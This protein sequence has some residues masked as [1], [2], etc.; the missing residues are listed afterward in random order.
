M[1][2]SREK[3]KPLIVTTPKAVINTGVSRCGITL[4]ISLSLSPL[5]SRGKTSSTRGNL[6]VLGNLNAGINK[7]NATL[8]SLKGWGKN[9]ARSARLP[10]HK[11][12]WW[13]L[14]PAATSEGALSQ[15]SGATQDS[16]PL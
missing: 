1:T 11:L 3:D 4:I 5:H 16:L 8:S 13:S 15:G 9:A 7:R 12:F 14:L 6:E 2:G 10:R